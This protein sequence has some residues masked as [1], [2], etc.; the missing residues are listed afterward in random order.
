MSV[1]AAEA[2]FAPTL[3]EPHLADPPAAPL[4]DDLARGRQM[5]RSLS[6][7]LD[8]VR[9]S[10]SALPHLAALEAALGHL[11]V[12]A[13]EQVQAKSLAKMLAQLRV[14][15]LDA[16]DGPVQDLLALVQRALRRLTREQREHQLSPH[17]P[18]STV[19][20]TETSESDFMN[21]LAEARGERGGH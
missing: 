12:M 5:Q 2:D 9:G 11:G 18:Q 7:L 8:R 21:A 6:G 10:R 14:L 13:L 1:P 20:I 15:P 3:R 4:D 19:I 16:A 17:D